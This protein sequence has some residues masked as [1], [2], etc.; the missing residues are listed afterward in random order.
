MKTI[1]IVI[2]V[3]N[4]A[5]Q[6]DGCLSSIAAQAIKPFEVIVVD[7]NSTD[8]SRAVAKSY[9]FVKL[10]S[11]KRQGVVHARTTGFNAAGGDI[12]ARIDADTILPNDW[13]DNLQQIFSNS[14]IDAVSGV[15]E[16]YNVSAAAFF[17]SIDLFFRRR[18]SL[19]LQ[20]RMYLWGA[21]MAIKRQAWLVV[22]PHLCQRGGQHEDYDLAIHLQEIGG[23]VSFDERLRAKVSSRRID[24]GYIDFMRY[25]WAS[26][27]TYAQHSIRLRYHMYPI[28]AVCGLGYLPARLMHLGYDA[29]KESFSLSRLFYKKPVLARVNPTANVV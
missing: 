29:E 25:V 6:L 7:N 24:S 17:N 11:E 15:A 19:Q 1:S 12:I 20:N 23:K 9:Q 10:L 16:Y 8:N 14:D 18:L 28:V 22:K 26:P 21:N 13:I 2:P 3:Y 5:D 4:E 27:Q